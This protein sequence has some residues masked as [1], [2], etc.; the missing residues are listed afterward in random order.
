MPEILPLLPQ[1]PFQRFGTT[2]NGTQHQLRARYVGRED[3]WYLDLLSENNTPI[4]MGMKVVLGA[5]MGIR[6]THPDMPGVFIARDLSNEEREA[7]LDD[8]GTR[9]I[10]YFFTFD[11]L[12]D[13]LAEIA[14]E[15]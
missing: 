14:A 15:S 10:V 7:T 9:V 1:I 6:S 13:A 4:R 8:L 2:L 3:A 11:E 12:A 5:Y